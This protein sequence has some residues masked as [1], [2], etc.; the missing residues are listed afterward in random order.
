MIVDRWRSQYDTEPELGKK[1]NEP[2]AE[3]AA[4]SALTDFCKEK[5]GVQKMLNFVEK[6]VQP[7]KSQKKEYISTA[8][9]ATETALLQKMNKQTSDNTKNIKNAQKKT[10]D[11]GKTANIW[12]QDEV[13]CDEPETR[14]MQGIYRGLETKIYET[15][16][17]S[18]DIQISIKDASRDKITRHIKNVDANL[19]KKKIDALVNDPE[20]VKK[21]FSA[22]MSGAVHTNV[23][24]ALNDISEKYKE[25]N[26]LEKNMS[27]LYDM[28]Q[29]LASIV[30]NQTELVNSITN[31]LT[32]A[33]DYIKKAVENLEKAQVAHK[34]GN[35]RL[36]C[37]TVIVVAGVG[38][39]MW[40]ILKMF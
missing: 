30:K 1:G 29:S 37:I 39:L 17:Q 7:L 21:L 31:N 23:K 6:S 25:L 32:G 35:K 34:Q 9:E 8:D 27:E 2:M 5:E 19:S 3:P 4:G 40:P 12:K 14:I 18:Q 20:G 24:N 36:W 28:I 26:K 33:R 13:L 15:L 16:K 11:L 10:K 22:Q 38:L